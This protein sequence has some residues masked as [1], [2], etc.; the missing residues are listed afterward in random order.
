MRLVFIFLLLL[1][2]SRPA[3]GALPDSV[4]KRVDQAQVVGQAMF[5]Y[6]FW[7]VY[8]ATL[9]APNGN[10][11]ETKPFA[12]ALTYQRDFKGRDIAERSVKEMRKQGV[13]DEEKLK[14]WGDAMQALFPDVTDGDTLLGIATENQVTHF[15]RGDTFLGEVEDKEFTKHFFAIWLGEKTSEPDLREKLLNQK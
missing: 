12:L 11:S 15:Y 6:Y 8:E 9:Y 14:R 13:E 4:D 3:F 5:T 1:S 7:D 10:W 2:A